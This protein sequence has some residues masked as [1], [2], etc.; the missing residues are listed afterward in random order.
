MTPSRAR[1]NHAGWP[2]MVVCILQG[3]HRDK[4]TRDRPHEQPTAGSA[5]QPEPRALTMY[6]A[7]I[8]AQCEAAA[9]P[10]ARFLR[11]DTKVAQAMRDDYHDEPLP[12]A[13]QCR[14]ECIESSR[15]KFVAA[16]IVFALGVDID[17]MFERGAELDANPWRDAQGF[18]H[19]SDAERESL[20][21][22]ILA[23]DERLM[24]PSDRTAFCFVAALKLGV[25]EAGSIGVA[26]F[27][28]CMADPAGSADGQKTLD[29]V[30][31]APRR[32]QVEQCTENSA[33]SSKARDR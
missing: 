5:S 10:K 6:R 14:R 3:C 24:N 8:E 30:V 13:E 11:S 25:Y 7:G 16:D 1:V 12:T 31:K 27:D 19:R 26:V 21:E 18:V 17:H 20:V 23:T 33:G 29:C 2:L 32:G 9:E 22:A 4:V 15:G 28:S